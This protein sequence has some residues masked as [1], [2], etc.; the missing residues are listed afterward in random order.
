MI[1]SQRWF[2]MWNS[3][4]KIQQNNRDQGGGELGEMSYRKEDKEK[5]FREARVGNDR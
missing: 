4:E 1:L 5:D 2:W 3:E